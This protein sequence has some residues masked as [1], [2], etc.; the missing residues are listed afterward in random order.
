MVSQ[1]LITRGT[2]LAILPCINGFAATACP[3]PYLE[4]KF[5]YIS[6][7]INA[8]LTSQ[9]EPSA[10]TSSKIWYRVRKSWSDAA[11]QKGAFH[12]LANAKKCA[13]NNSGLLLSLMILGKTLYPTTAASKNELPYKVKVTIKI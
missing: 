12:N 11:T 2:N 1:S 4:S 3:G 10:P 8:K 6:Q 9:V 7:E 5:L 13:D